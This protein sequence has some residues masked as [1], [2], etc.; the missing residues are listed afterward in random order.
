MS[1]INQ[2]EKSLKVEEEKRIIDKLLALLS[3]EDPNLYYTDSHSVAVLVFDKIMKREGISY[4]EY[5]LVKDL[6]VN[7]VLIRMSYHTNCC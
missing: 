2:Q 1:A 4:Q 3:Q 6:S 7:D 5:E